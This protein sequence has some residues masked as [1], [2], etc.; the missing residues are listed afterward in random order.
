MAA[1]MDADARVTPRR[2][3]TGARGTFRTGQAAVAYGTRTAAGGV[4]PG[5]GGGATPAATRG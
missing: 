1:L 4:A 5:E 2:G 3:L